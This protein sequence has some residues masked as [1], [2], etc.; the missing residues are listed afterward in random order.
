MYSPPP[1]IDDSQDA[2][3]DL[4]QRHSV[5]AANEQQQQV[6]DEIYVWDSRV[7]F[8]TKFKNK[9]LLLLFEYLKQIWVE[10]LALISF[11]VKFIL[12]N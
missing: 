4:L 2:G 6:Y 1:P 9:N 3:G 5:L 8:F 10:I 11:V 7:N 12:V